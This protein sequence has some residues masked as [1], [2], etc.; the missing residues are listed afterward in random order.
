[1]NPPPPPNPHSPSRSTSDDDDDDDDDTE[2]P[3]QPYE[4][5]FDPRSI[6]RPDPA[7]LTYFI[8]ISAFTLVLFPFVF[9]PLY[10]KYRTL[11]YEFD[12]DG[13]SMRWGVLFRQEINL[14][15]RR[16]QDIHVT[17]GLI[18]R[19]LGLASLAIQTASGASGAEM[20]ILGIRRPEQLRD[21]LYRTMGGAEDEADESTP[22]Q[23][24]S[25]LDGAATT[26][27][28]TTPAG[29][30]TDDEAL[31]L[32]RD[33]RDEIRSFAA[34]RHAASPLESEAGE[35]RSRPSPTSTFPAEETRRAPEREAE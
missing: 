19:W 22:A 23:R 35:E 15:Y 7:L 32:L 9:L 5:T 26:A 1:M 28:A 24:A 3:A 6:R 29:A 16:I 31:A 14:T 12:E 17:R 33:I 18:Q 10:F 20:T 34:R 8:I 2:S 13:I 21:Y 11:E 27:E 4:S 30:D 25:R